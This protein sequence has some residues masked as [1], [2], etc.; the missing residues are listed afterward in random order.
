MS[1]TVLNLIA[2][3]KEFAGEWKERPNP[4]LYCAIMVQYKELH[5]EL[6]YAEITEDNVIF[7][8]V[9]A[10]AKLRSYEDLAE[11]I[12]LLLSGKE[13]RE[14]NKYIAELKSLAFDWKHD[15]AEWK[16]ST[17]GAIICKFPELRKSIMNADIIEDNAIFDF[18]RTHDDIYT[19]DD[20]LEFIDILSVRKDDEETL[21]FY[22]LEI[23]KES[24]ART[25][26]FKIF[27]EDEDKNLLIADMEL[28]ESKEFCYIMSLFVSEPYR[29]RGYGTQIL[30]TV[31]RKHNHVYICPLNDDN[32]RLF[33]RI[34]EKTENF[35]RVLQ[36]TVDL[37]GCI[38]ELKV[39]S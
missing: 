3:L 13:I 36:M 29:N 39:S 1:E 15:E 27:D 16:C 18:V 7:D 19:Y 37:V 33:N 26:K 2:E 6:S 35:P 31:A 8:F 24:D 11:F 34:G 17:E 25:V 30:K 4:F 14:I 12:D 5:K 38:Y 10:H 28:F 9:K 22:E 21:K 23:K 32:V 20:L